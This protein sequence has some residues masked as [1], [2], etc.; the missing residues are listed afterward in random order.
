MKHIHKK[1][2][3]KFVVLLLISLLFSTFSSILPAHAAPG[4]GL[5]SDYG[6][7]VTDGNIDMTV[8]DFTLKWIHAS[9][10]ELQF[11]KIPNTPPLIFTPNKDVF[12]SSTGRID[13]DAGYIN[14]FRAKDFGCKAWLGFDYSEGE[15][16]S[17]EDERRKIALVLP[18]S[19]GKAKLE[20]KFRG[21]ETGECEQYANASIVR[22]GNGLGFQ[23]TNLSTAYF[24]WTGAGRISTTDD[25]KPGSFTE[26]SPGSDVFWRDAEGPGTTCRDKLIVNR[27]EN[28]VRWFELKDGSFSNNKTPH[29]DAQAP[30]C[31]MNN[32]SKPTGGVEWPLIGSES[33]PDE[34]LATTADTAGDDSDPCES[35]VDSGW[36]WWICPLLTATDQLITIV[37]N[38]IES[39]LE[40]RTQFTTNEGLREAWSNMAR[41]SSGL[42]VII[43]LVMIIST[44]L[45]VEIV[46]SYTMKK[47]LPRIVIGA[48]GIWLSWALATTYINFMN[49]LGWGI[50]ELLY[51]PFKDLYSIPFEEVNLKYI[52]SVAIGEAGPN[53][54]I[55]VGGGGAILAGA[56]LLAFM[57]SSSGVLG[58]I[59]MAIPVIAAV[60]IGLFLLSLREVIIVFLLVLSPIGAAAW[61][62]PNTEKIWKLWSGTFNKLLL[63]F[64]LFMGAFAAGKIFA[65]IA[66]KNLSGG[67]NDALDAIIPTIAY[68]SPFF[69]I[70]ALFKLA[71]STFS[72]ITGMVNNKTKGLVDK[73]TGAIKKRGETT[74]RALRK[75]DR[76]TEKLRRRG[77]NYAGGL[78][79]GGIKA[80]YR[81][82]MLGKNR[83][84]IATNRQ[85]LLGK[86]MS[87]ALK[88]ETADHLLDYLE[89]GD[90]TSAAAEAYIKRE[91]SAGRKAGPEDIKR[92]TAAAGASFKRYGSAGYSKSPIF[93]ASALTQAAETGSYR[94]SAK[95]AAEGL[96]S[97]GNAED[98]ALMGSAI[99][100]A[101]VI[102][103]KAGYVGEFKPLPA[104]TPAGTP[105]DTSNISKISD[106]GAVSDTS[107]GNVIE[108]VGESVR[109]TGG[110]TA[111][112]FSYTDSGGVAQT[113]AGVKFT[114]PAVNNIVNEL[115]RVTSGSKTIDAKRKIALDS[116]LDALKT[117][118][119]AVY[120]TVMGEVNERARIKQYF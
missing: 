104:G 107:M 57:S 87:E 84:T 32:N 53:A 15:A 37:E 77:L 103:G 78:Q 31:G 24:G 17:A 115:A 59:T 83:S 120:A 112:T 75:K 72:N 76:D 7:T 67:S 39:R 54:D 23:N 11:T 88:G 49:D 93:A 109:A 71:G 9:R 28:T 35:A 118:Q 42:L 22:N 50:A 8:N 45:G 99:G 66:V 48:I 65:L 20:I 36:G 114:D 96:V 89:F 100:G 94:D 12:S 13:A 46:S 86:E 73:T 29:E 44:A 30:D 69:F 95:T 105:P 27:T 3:A 21:S 64:P 70:P 90:N 4:D 16:G 25:R 113:H 58:I 51:S 38:Q 97:G 55:V 101:K 33:S 117:A 108:T 2:E 91:A 52:T 1:L 80:G 111:Q 119:P 106:I 14:E 110:A 60:L 43:A 81:R 18:S 62:L 10:I 98:K 68:V 63:L 6:F 74:N 34:D 47:L 82:A 19:G 41:I 102:A 79:G 85:R 5:A 92:Y 56:G 26:S 116:Q 61:I 40:V